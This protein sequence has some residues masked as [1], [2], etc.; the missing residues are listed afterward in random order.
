MSWNRTK[1]DQCAYRKDLSQSTSPMIYSLDP[2]KFYNNTNCRP[3]FGLIAGNNVSVTS[4]NMVDLESDLIGITRQAS[5][6]PERK[7]LPHCRHCD[8]TSGLPCGTEGCKKTESLQHLQE[9]K[10]ID[11]SPRIDHIGYNIKYTQCPTANGAQKMV[12][13]P[14]MNPTQYVTKQ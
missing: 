4:D 11:Y 8:E 12:Y 6:C 7:Y 5:K 13:P 1:Y 3:N 14:Q 10:I 2:N 9:C